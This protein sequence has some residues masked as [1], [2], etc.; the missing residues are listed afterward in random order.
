MTARQAVLASMVGA[1]HVELGSGGPSRKKQLTSE[2]IALRREETARKR[3]NLNE[4]KLEDEKTETINRLLKK[5]SSRSRAKRTALNS[6]VVPTPQSPHSGN[7][8]END[9]DAAGVGGGGINANTNTSTT[10]P[11]LRT[12][13]GPAW[14]WIS[15]QEGFILGIPKEVEPVVGVTPASAMTKAEKKPPAPAICDVRGCREKRKY[16][17]V[18]DFTKGA[19]GMPHLKLLGGKV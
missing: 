12:I 7:E 11:R 15:T 4:K 13:P 2:E 10:D 6:S 17:L 1:E 18:G 3:K 14:R 5:Q 19:C 16:R 9:S 8:N